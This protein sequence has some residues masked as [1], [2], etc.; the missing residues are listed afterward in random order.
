MQNF[1]NVTVAK[2]CLNS[3]YFRAATQRNATP[4][5]PLVMLFQRND[6]LVKSR[7]LTFKCGPIMRNLQSPVTEEAYYG[8]N[9]KA[10]IVPLDHRHASIFRF[11]G[12]TECKTCFT[13]LILSKLLIPFCNNADT[14]GIFQR[15]EDFNKSENDLY[16]YIGLAFLKEVALPRCTSKAMEI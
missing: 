15:Q 7:I 6:K 11:Y 10:A 1:P 5:T 12:I 13:T 9:M 2:S 4:I 14:K 3:E 16:S 8:L